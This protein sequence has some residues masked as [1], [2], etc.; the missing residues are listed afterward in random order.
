[1][2]SKHSVKAFAL[3]ILVEL[4][5][6]FL[7]AIVGGLI[8]LI[9]II[10]WIIAIIIEVSMFFSLISFLFKIIGQLMS[11]AEITE[12]GV[13]GRSGLKTFDLTWDKVDSV[14][15]GTN[16]LYVKTLRKK[17]YVIDNISNEN[18]LVSEY[19]RITGKGS[20][21]F[22][23]A[24]REAERQAAKKAAKKAEK[25]AKKNKKS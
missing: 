13:K 3:D 21:P 5:W 4:V 12:G 1:M 7:V 24:E 19:H 17:P 2:K 23:E 15:L 22:K 18:E 14:Y 8:A 11:H 25:E 6:R 9:P 10:G 16:C 20:D